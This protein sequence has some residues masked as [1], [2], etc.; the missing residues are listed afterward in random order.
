MT[1]RDRLLAIH[2]GPVLEWLE[3]RRQAKVGELTADYRQGK[4]TRDKAGE[5]TVL[6]DLISALRA[7]QTN[8]EQQGR[9]NANRN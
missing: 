7:K 4:D 8:Y 6:S 3:E 2:A 5:L 9:K 1:D